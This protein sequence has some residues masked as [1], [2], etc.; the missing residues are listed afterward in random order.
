MAK[1]IRL[2]LIMMKMDSPREFLIYCGIPLGIISLDHTP[3]V[4]VSGSKS[5]FMVRP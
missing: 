5:T 2:K 1:D 3:G 4:R